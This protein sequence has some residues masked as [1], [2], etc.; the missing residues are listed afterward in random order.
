MNRRIIETCCVIVLSLGIG[1]GPGGQEQAAEP[2]SAA[3]SAAEARSQGPAFSG[4][5]RVSG[6]T[7][8]K[9]TGRG[10]NIAG[11]IILVQEGDRYVATFDLETAFPNPSGGG[12][13]QA[14]VIGKGEGTVQKTTLRGTAETQIV[15]AEVPG[16]DPSFGFMPRSYGP[17]LVSD[18][19][20]EIQE[21]GDVVVEIEN[22]AAPGEEYSPT[23]T[24]LRGARVDASK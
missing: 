20:T 24:T 4:M 3:G 13:T 6:K 8:E 16:V 23:H 2:G 5:Y 11:T 17:R 7:V 18:A 1:C 19:V 22:R 10:R 9:A 14:K 15:W 12:A 21:N